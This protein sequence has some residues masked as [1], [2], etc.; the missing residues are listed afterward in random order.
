MQ[1]RTAPVTAQKM[2]IS[3]QCY[4]RVCIYRVDSVLAAHVLVLRLIKGLLEGRV[5]GSDSDSESLSR[6]VGISVRRSQRL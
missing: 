4:V 5:G 1:A 3:V 6:S 2:I